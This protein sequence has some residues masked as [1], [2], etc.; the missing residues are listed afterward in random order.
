MKGPQQQSCAPGW[1]G[2]QGGVSPTLAGDR[3]L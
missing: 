2:E 3:H 1:Q